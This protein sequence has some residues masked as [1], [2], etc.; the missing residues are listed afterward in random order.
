[1]YRYTKYK[2]A[3]V[4]SHCNLQAVKRRLLDC[5]KGRRARYT[6]RLFQYV[7]KM[8]QNSMIQFDYCIIF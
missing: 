4:L 1:M 7:T 8:K 2:Y 5:D 6:L 3:Q